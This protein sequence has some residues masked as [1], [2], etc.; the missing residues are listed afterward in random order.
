M[1]KVFCLF[2]LSIRGFS[3]VVESYS[4]P[5]ICYR[6][7][8]GSGKIISSKTELVDLH[9]TNLEFSRKLIG[10][11]EGEVRTFSLGKIFE[12]KIIKADASSEV[13]AASSDFALSLLG[14]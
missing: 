3:Q 12:V 7:C 2:F 11:K 14:L 13:H 5:L 9:E 1:G 10:M 4:T 6:E 8:D